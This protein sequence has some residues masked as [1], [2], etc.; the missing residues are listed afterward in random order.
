MILR[1]LRRILHLSIT[2]QTTKRRPTDYDALRDEMCRNLAAGLG[3]EWPP[4][5]KAGV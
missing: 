1:F 5:G 3:R 4:A 2:V